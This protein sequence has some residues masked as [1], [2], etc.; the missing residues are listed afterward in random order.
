MFKRFVYLYIFISFSFSQN[1]Q[2][3]EIVSSNQDSYYDEDGDTPDWIEIYNPTSN[4][5]SLDNWGLS[6]D[7]DDLDKWKFPQC[8]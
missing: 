5:I 4:T 1:I 3:N 2:I 6:D 8:A 7:I